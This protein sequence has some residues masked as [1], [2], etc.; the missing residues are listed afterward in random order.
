MAAPARRVLHHIV[1]QDLATEESSGRWPA[2]LAFLAEA[3]LAL[4]DVETAALLRPRLDEYAGHNLVMGVS[5]AVFG[6]ADRYRGAIDSLLGRGTTD[7]HF[8]RALDLEVT[9][10]SVLHQA[11]TLAAWSVHAR[12]VG[13]QARSRS[14]DRAPR[15]L[16]VPQGMTRVLAALVEPPKGAVHG[17][18]PAGLTDREVEV[19]RLLDEGPSNR[20]IARRLVISESA[21]ANHVRGILLKT[22][23]EN[24]TQAAR[25]AAHHGLLTD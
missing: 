15:W 13:A 18:Y 1:Q 6:A 14:L 19:M 21:A 24:R 20:E 5:T 22:G 23:S 7:T 8:G 10:G 12:R 9:T 11:H 16:A 25:F 4:E 3:G 17:L 2:T